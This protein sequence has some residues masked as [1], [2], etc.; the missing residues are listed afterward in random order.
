MRA[1]APRVAAR[2]EDRE[3]RDQLDAHVARLASPAAQRKPAGDF[4]F[5]ADGTARVRRRRRL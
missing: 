3:H 5:I 4:D 1:L 2:G